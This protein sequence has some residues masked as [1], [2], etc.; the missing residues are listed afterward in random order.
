VPEGDARHLE[1]ARLLLDP[2][3]VG[4]HDFRAFEELE[5]LEVAEGFEHRDA[6]GRLD[7]E[8]AH[9]DPGPGVGGEEHRQPQLLRDHAD[10]FEGVGEALGVVDVLL[11]VEG[12]E[13]VLAGR[14][15]GQ[16]R[17][18]DEGR[19]PLHGV[20]DR[21]ASDVHPFGDPLALEV[22]P[23]QLGGGEEEG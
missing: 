10:A 18:V 9:A 22:P 21:V 8:L 11:P 16:L 3:R 7:A 6:F 19:V 4:E 1:G 23:R 14:V 15:D 2:A 5:E 12:E 20:H 17:P 13:R